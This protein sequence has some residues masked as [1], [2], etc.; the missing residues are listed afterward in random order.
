M[1][2]QE[3]AAAS[4]GDEEEARRYRDAQAAFLRDHL[5]VWGPTFCRRLAREAEHPFYAA[6]ARRLAAWLEEEAERFGLRRADAGPP[7]YPVAVKAR[8]CTLC[9]VCAEAC[10]PG[11][12]RLRWADGE[13]QL[14]LVSEACTGCRLCAEVC[15]F[16][17]LRLGEQPTA[18]V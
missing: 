6:L 2:A 11:A 8:L 16:K 9:G 15:P 17:A 18:G 10:T 1:A 5:L 14:Y 7:A 3:E 13:A 4:V 12:L